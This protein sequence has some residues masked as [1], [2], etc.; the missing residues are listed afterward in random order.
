M[1]LKYIDNQACLQ[2]FPAR[3][4]NQ[5]HMPHPDDPATQGELESLSQAI[6]DGLEPEQILALIAQRTCQVLLVTE[7]HIFLKQGQALVR[8]AS[9]QE[10]ETTPLLSTLA[11]GE[12][13][14]GW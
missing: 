7:A 3:T 1:A 5:Q 13:I 14:E 11:L 2:P 9:H 10:G 8:T 6:A 4:R 12:G